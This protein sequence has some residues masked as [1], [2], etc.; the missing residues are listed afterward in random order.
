MKERDKGRKKE[1]HVPHLPQLI[2]PGLR[3]GSEDVK[4]QIYKLLNWKCSF[5][6]LDSHFELMYG[7]SACVTEIVIKCFMNLQQ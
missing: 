3:T 4:Q 2:P 1:G 5:Y 7:G 6:L